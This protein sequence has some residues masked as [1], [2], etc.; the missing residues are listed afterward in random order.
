MTRL[1][2]GWTRAALG[3]VCDI[4]D[5][6]RIPVNAAERERR[7]GDVPYYGATGQVGWIDD[8]IF[9]QELVLLGE[10][11]APF[12]DPAKPKAYLIRGRSWVNNHAHVLRARGCILSAFLLHQLNT[13]DYHPF[14]TGTTRLKL[15]QA[16]MRTIPLFVAPLPEQRRIVAALEE[17]LSDLD[18][19]VSGLKRALTNVSGFKSAVLERVFRD[20]NSDDLVPLGQLVAS[21]MIGL[22][23]GRDQQN[24]DGAGVAYVKMNNVTTD[25]RVVLDD[26]AFVSVSPDEGRRY[27]IED[28]DLLFN[29]RNSVELVGKTGLVRRPPTGAVFNNN[30]MRIRAAAHV[31]PE[32]LAWQMVAPPFRRKLDQVKRATT[33]VAAIYAKDLLPLQLRMPALDRQRTE[34][35]QIE[36]Q[37]AVADRT[38]AEIDVQLARAAHLRQ[39]ILKRAFEGRLVPQDP[40]DEPASALLSHIRSATIE[41]AASAARTRSPRPRTTARPGRA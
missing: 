20:T 23:R 34:V 14:V 10:D 22:D 39:S 5:S 36:R 6:R 17:H 26:L 21:T 37:L 12:L 4:L 8:F 3:D 40:S 13:V 15:P 38:G 33:N 41:S 32:Y 18:A 11:G 24:R 35:E 25:G 7:L 28:G 29:T 31:L 30:L 19:A 27:E 16:P 9:D 2:R 1:P